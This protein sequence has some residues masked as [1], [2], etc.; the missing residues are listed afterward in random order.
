MRTTS[1]VLVACASLGLLLWCGCVGQNLAG[2]TSET[3][4]GRLSGK[5]TLSD[6]T[7]AQGGTVRVIEDTA[8][9]SKITYGKSVSVGSAVIDDSG[10]FSVL[11]PLTRTINL[12][13]D[14]GDEARFLQG[15]EKMFD[16]NAATAVRD[17]TLAPHASVTGTATAVDGTAKQVRL[18]GTAYAAALNADGSYAFPSVAAGAF[19][20]VA[21]VE[22]AAGLN[23]SLVNSIEL[24]AGQQAAGLALRVYPDR[25]LVDDFS[26]GFGRTALGRVLGDGAWYTTSDSIAGGGS[27]VTVS[28]TLDSSGRSGR[29]IR[30]IYALDSSVAD[31]WAVCGFD[32]GTSLSGSAYDFSGLTA[33]SF[34]AKGRGT[35]QV[36]LLSRI[37]RQLYRD[38]AQYCFSVNV[39]AA[40][41][42]ITIPVDSLRL[43]SNAPDALRNI[44]WQ[45]AA[46]EIQTMD[47]TVE[48][49]YTPGG[50]TVEFWLDDVAFEGISL[51]D[52]KR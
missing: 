26:T 29:C 13:I 21:Q 45:Q 35:V 43:P 46:R 34:V 15:A 48:S 1:I 49:P 7:A 40:W 16:T 39:P 8:W 36:T 11:V 33:V 51:E 24:S 18:A 38:S 3:T 27:N 5:V 4:N 32:V 20:I 47:F 44:T 6:G 9:L 22:Q 28:V 41:T 17:F 42:Q 30:A 23:V 2:A 14:C 52:L 25:V 19:A 12:Q 10:R 31:P 37:I 50:D